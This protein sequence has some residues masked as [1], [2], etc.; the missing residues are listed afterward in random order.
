MTLAQLIERHEA[1]TATP[2]PR[3][4]AAGTVTPRGMATIAV[5]R[6]L[7]ALRE[8]SLE[9]RAAIREILNEELTSIPNVTA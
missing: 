8:L 1:A 4:A 9:D 2:T 6:L 7:R 3:H 5:Y